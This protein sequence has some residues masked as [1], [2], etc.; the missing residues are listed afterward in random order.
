M[1]AAAPFDVIWD[2]EEKTEWFPWR[3]TI[4]HY[5]W[6]SVTLTHAWLRLYLCEDSHWNNTSPES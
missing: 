3:W 5:L 4:I 6:D 1:M 2:A